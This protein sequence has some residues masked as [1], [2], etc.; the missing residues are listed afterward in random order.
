MSFSKFLLVPLV[1]AT[2]FAYGDCISNL[3][4][5]IQALAVE[6]DQQTSADDAARKSDSISY[7]NNNLLHPFEDAKK[8]DSL[9]LRQ[10]HKFFFDEYLISTKFEDFVGAISLVNA[11]CDLPSTFITKDDIYALIVKELRNTG[12]INS[13][14]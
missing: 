8:G 5:R 1:L 4:A 13:C 3:K 11:S 2:S 7:I 6:R 14:R 9:F 12:K 10:L